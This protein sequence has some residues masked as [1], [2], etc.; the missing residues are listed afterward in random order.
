LGLTP[1]PRT[2]NAACF[3]PSSEFLG[4]PHHGSWTDRGEGRGVRRLPHRSPRG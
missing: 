3:F 4:H 1:L 2:T